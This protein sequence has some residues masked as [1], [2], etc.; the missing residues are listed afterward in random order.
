M[1][2]IKFVLLFFTVFIVLCLSLFAVTYYLL[3]KIDTSVSILILGKGGEG[4]TAPD[5]TDTIILVN[6]NPKSKKVTA[7]SLPRDIWIPAIRA[8]LNTAY[9]YGRFDL[10]STSVASVTG[11]TP[12]YYLV[13]DFSLFQDLVDVIGGIDVSVDRDFVDEKY[14]IDGKEEDLC[15]GDK[16]YKCRYETL[17]FSQGKQLMDG[18]TTLKFVRSRN[19]V[20][21]EGTDIARER[22]Q[23]KVLE[24]IK[25]KLLSKEILLNP[26][27]IQ[28]LYLT[29]IANI[30]TDI[31]KKM[32]LK[33]LRFIFESKDNIKFLSIPEEYIKISQNDKKYDFQYVFIPSRSSWKEFQNWLNSSFSN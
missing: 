21:D 24:A 32:A 11:L 17:R 22:R 20:G 16:L 14:P 19:A 25:D 13:I 29:L 1:R 10:V 3:P 28:K 15:D 27:A 23:Q 2:I 30:E 33:L 8:K 6:L 12:N 31:D 9:H 18:D 4:H 7:I 5:L 26:E